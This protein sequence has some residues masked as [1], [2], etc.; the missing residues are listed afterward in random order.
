MKKRRKYVSKK[1]NDLY[2]NA[3]LE[4]NEAVE[5]ALARWSNNPKD[6]CAM[7]EVYKSILD[8]DRECGGL[9][10]SV[11]S[12]DIPAGADNIE[13]FNGDKA[14]YLNRS[15][16]VFGDKFILVFTSRDRFRV[17]NDTAG[18]VMFIREVF[19]LLSEMEGID[20]IVM[21]LHK[22]EVLFTRQNMKQ[23]SR[24]IEMWEEEK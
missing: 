22:E 6:I 20:G 2:V 17:C 15:K 14:L 19:S 13:F 3:M 10:V 8:R 16:G 18:V 11:E 9:I 4:G 24:L 23:I 5:A 1:E 12:N 7:I 21:N